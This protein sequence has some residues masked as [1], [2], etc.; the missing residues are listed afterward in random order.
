M[1]TGSEG[2]DVIIAQTDDLS[3]PTLSPCPSSLL[4]LPESLLANI[5]SYLRGGPALIRSLRT[6][7]RVFRRTI[8]SKV[9]THEQCQ[10][11]K[12]GLVNV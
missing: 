8:D 12:M 10:R 7:S 4:C 1:L 9:I 2:E 3:A 6:V 5:L 11:L